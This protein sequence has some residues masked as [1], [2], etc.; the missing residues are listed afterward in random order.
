TDTIPGEPRTPK[1]AAVPAVT[2]G[3]G[4][5]PS[6]IQTS[7]NARSPYHRGERWQTS[8]GFGRQ[9]TPGRKPVEPPSATMP[10]TTDSVVAIVGV[11]GTGSRAGADTPLTI[12]STGGPSGSR[13]GCWPHADPA[14]TA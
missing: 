5:R 14:T 10:S 13:A 6:L 3:V 11:S 12:A 8:H 4:L 2:S 1:L 9:S 7:R